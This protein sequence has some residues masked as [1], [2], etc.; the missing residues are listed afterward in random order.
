MQSSHQACKKLAYLAPKEKP[1]DAQEGVLGDLDVLVVHQ[2]HHSFFR[3]E[4]CYDDSPCCMVLLYK[5]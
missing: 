3:L 4:V 5:L 2:F 1:L